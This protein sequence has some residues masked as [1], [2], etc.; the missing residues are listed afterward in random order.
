[1][2]NKFIALLFSSFLVLVSFCNCTSQ[3]STTVERSSPALGNKPLVVGAAQLSTY[4]HILEDKKIGLVVNNTSVVNKT[5]LLDTLL[6]SGIDIVKI[7]APEHGF[8]GTAD[9]G[10]HVKDETDLAT[11]LPI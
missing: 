10:E 3:L 11:G 2:F 5:H 9:N 7:F 6:L 8:R 4:L 1:M